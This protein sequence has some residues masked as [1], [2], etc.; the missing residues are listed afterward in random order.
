MT[1]ISQYANLPKWI[2]ELSRLTPFARLYLYPV[3][4]Y[5]RKTDCDLISPNFPEDEIDVNFILR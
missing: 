1:Q 2:D 5:W 4:A 3:A